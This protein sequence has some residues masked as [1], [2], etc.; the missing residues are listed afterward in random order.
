[1]SARS[2]R[3]SPGENPLLIFVSSVMDKGVEDLQWAR[4]VVFNVVGDTP[5]LRSWLFEYTP[6]SSEDV[7][8]SYLSKVRESDFFVWLVGKHTTKP[9][10][11]EIREAL[12]S[13]VRMLI[14]KLPVEER[15]S[16]TLDLLG[17]VGPKAKYASVQSRQY[18]G[19]EIEETLSDEL[20]R[21]VREHPGADP[22]D[23]WIEE[24]ARHSRLRCVQGWVAAGVPYS[25]AGALADDESVVSS[26]TRQFGEKEKVRLIFGPLGAGKSLTA[27]RLFQSAVMSYKNDTKEP[28]PIH[29]PGRAL[30]DCCLEEA[31]L[32][33]LPS[34]A[35]PKDRGVYTVVDDITHL[36]MQKRLELLA[37]ANA[38]VDQSPNSVFTFTC[39][40]LPDMVGEWPHTR[41]DLLPESAAIDLVNMLS[42]ESYTTVDLNYR[43]PQSVRSSIQI[44]LFAILLGN[45]LRNSAGKSPRSSVEMIRS[46][47]DRVQLEFDGDER[48]QED[49]LC[50][51]AKLCTNQQSD[52]VAKNELGDSSVI[53]RLVST[54]LV[55]TEGSNIGFSLQ[56]MR[57]WYGCL[58]LRQRDPTAAEIV[59][60]RSLLD[61]WYESLLLLIRTGDYN[62]AS[63][64]LGQ[65]ARYDPGCAASAVH[66]AIDKWPDDSPPSLP[67][68]CECERRMNSC[69]A[70]WVGGIG[71]LASQIA[72]VNDDGQVLP[73][74]VV[75]SQGALS[76]AWFRGEVAESGIPDLP[77]NIFTTDAEAMNW[78]GAAFTHASSQPTWPWR[79]TLE[80][81]RSNLEQLLG[82][83]GI[84]PESG[85]GL[86]ETVW[87]CALGM[88]GQGSL[89]REALPLARLVI[90]R[91][92]PDEAY[93]QGRIRGL[94]VRH[95]RSV[96]EPLLAAGR[97]ELPPPWPTADLQLVGRSGLIVSTYS[98]E[99][100][101]R[102]LEGIFSGA[103][104]TYRQLVETWFKPFAPRLGVYSLM[105]VEV[106]G[107][108]RH[109]PED[110]QD[111]SVLFWYMKPLARSGSDS[112]E[113]VEGDPRAAGGGR[114]LLDSLHTSSAAS[115]PDRGRFASVSTHFTA[116][117][118]FVHSY[119]VT[120][121]AYGWLWHDLEKLRWIDGMHRELD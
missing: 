69:M 72:P 78:R 89:R 87:N 90:P 118:V 18:L 25:V 97:S 101:R 45:Y 60:N 32:A 27:N 53:R 12:R 88:L 51:L 29:V 85:I 96:L 83:Y 111:K 73:I 95:F 71:D 11:R 13:P 107:V 65:V 17:E 35:L 61:S 44:P 57:H 50:Q 56:L 10:K 54:G 115:R 109:S 42:G 48:S 4:D 108:L 38:L 8:S 102:R 79:L 22:L 99:A 67:P 30:A 7:S 49:S 112:V 113:I 103:L 68:D 116:A 52:M 16:E 100:L 80:R 1:M 58:A 9:V 63:E 39:R 86:H 106:Q 93:M 70:S 120:N 94:R 66:E 91:N 110:S 82:A 28:I 24:Q 74:R 36:R 59:Q 105:P 92:V 3:P 14:F 31:L 119:P 37:E 20:I 104:E 117:S 2:G 46:I 40:E 43:W 114:K 21:A 77:R 121:L 41:I 23:T 33:R 84:I 75:A 19:S 6:A 98:L 76:Y 62:S 55:R 64:Y 15:T 26:L 34:G 81:L 47:A 5:F